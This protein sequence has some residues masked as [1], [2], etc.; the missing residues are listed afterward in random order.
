[1]KRMNIKLMLLLGIMLYLFEIPLHVSADELS[2]TE[3]APEQETDLDLSD[4]DALAEGY[5]NEQLG[6][7]A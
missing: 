3:A 5:I 6:G 4:G 7:I 2:L 1:M